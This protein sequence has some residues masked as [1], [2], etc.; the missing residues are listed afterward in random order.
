MAMSMSPYPST[1]P[2]P[3]ELKEILPNAKHS[4]ELYVLQHIGIR[5]GIF[6][7]K[8]EPEYP[9]FKKSSIVTRTLNSS[10]NLIKNVEFI[11]ACLDYGIKP[12]PTKKGIEFGEVTLEVTEKAKNDMKAIYRFWGANLK[13]RADRC[14][15]HPSKKQQFLEEI[16]I[17]MIQQKSYK[18]LRIPKSKLSLMEPCNKKEFFEL[19]YDADWFVKETPFSFILTPRE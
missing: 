6:A 13:E 12:V 2:T 1:L 17:C 19:C 7:I 9:I 14:Y 5:M 8:Q 3:G 10:P 16:F 4:P 11:L 18:K 15:R